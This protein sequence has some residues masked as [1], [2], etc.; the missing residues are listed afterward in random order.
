MVIAFLDRQI[1]ALCEDPVIS[2]TKFGVAISKNLQTRLADISAV[3]NLTELPPENQ[4]QAGN[5]DHSIYI[6]DLGEGYGLVFCSNHIK[7]KP[8]NSFG[9]IDWNRVTRIKILKIEKI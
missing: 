2:A 9:N 6:L 5:E 3:E 7:N 1:R 8:K 4:G